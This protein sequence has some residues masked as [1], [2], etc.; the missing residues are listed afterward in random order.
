[1]S[2][3]NLKRLENRLYLTDDPLAFTNL[4]RTGLTAKQL[5]KACALSVAYPLYSKKSPRT[6]KHLPSYL[7]TP[8]FTM[9]GLPNFLVFRIC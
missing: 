4:F 6:I 8:D 5:S 2:D 3:W 7:G 1:M 9:R